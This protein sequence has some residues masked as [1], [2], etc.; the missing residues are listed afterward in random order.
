M[1]KSRVSSN[2]DVQLQGE[3]NRPTG[4]PQLKAEGGKE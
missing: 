3:E 2:G 4:A 1:E